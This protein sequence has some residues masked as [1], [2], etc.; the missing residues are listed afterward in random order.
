MTHLI[1]PEISATYAD[2]TNTDIHTHA[3]IHFSFIA[4]TSL[5][6]RLES[7]LYETPTHKRS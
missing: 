1:I 5:I 2:H 6:T 4:D 7:L 3:I